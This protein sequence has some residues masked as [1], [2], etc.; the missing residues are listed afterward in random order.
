M[1]GRGRKHGRPDSGEPYMSMYIASPEGYPSIT[2]PEFI[3]LL[4]SEGMTDEKLV[5]Y[6]IGWQA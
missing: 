3:R 2:K 1:F 4:K 5:N 6:Q